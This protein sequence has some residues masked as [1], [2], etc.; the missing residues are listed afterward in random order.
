MNEYLNNWWYWKDEHPENTF[1]DVFY[2]TSLKEVEKDVFEA[3]GKEAVFQSSGKD[4][5]LITVSTM[6]GKIIH[7][8]T[9]KELKPI[10]HLEAIKIIDTWLYEDVLEE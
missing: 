8:D 2:F 4:R 3:E 7:R 9:L 6:H 1:K 10:C 5:K